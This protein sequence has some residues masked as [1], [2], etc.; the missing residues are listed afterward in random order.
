VR[1]LLIDGSVL[2]SALCILQMW[3]LS[4]KRRSG[5]ALGILILVLAIPFDY[6]TDQYGYIVSALVSLVIS[7]RAYVGWASD[8]R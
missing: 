1:W 7:W 5:W 6:M 4:K 3:L 8:E 2:F